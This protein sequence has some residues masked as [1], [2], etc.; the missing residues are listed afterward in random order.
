V[1]YGLEMNR[2]P[3]SEKG[4]GFY[5]SWDVINVIIS[6]APYLT[7]NIVRKWLNK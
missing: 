5:S 3:I 6:K 7:K 1:G 4:M 2:D